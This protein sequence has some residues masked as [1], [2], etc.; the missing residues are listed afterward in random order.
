MR[1]WLADFWP[2]LLIAGFF[3]LAMIALTRE[4]SLREGEIYDKTFH[5]AHTTMIL[6]PVTISTG[7]ST[8]TTLIPMW[9]YY[10]DSWSIDIKKFNGKKWLKATWWVSEDVYDQAVVGGY[11]KVTKDDLDDQ[12]RMETDEPTA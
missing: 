8:T 10:P 12:P 6:M 3:I 2:L 9:F 11:Y 1:D 5:P 7:K 4:P